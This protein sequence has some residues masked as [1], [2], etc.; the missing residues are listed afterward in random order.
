MDQI[1]VLDMLFCPAFSVKNGLIDDVNQDAKNMCITAGEPVE[2]MLLSGKTEYQ[3][4]PVGGCLSVLVDTETSEVRAFVC[5]QEDRDLFLLDQDYEDP[6]L[7]ALNVASNDLRLPLSLV[8]Q[9]VYNARMY[10]QPMDAKVEK[11]LNLIYKGAFQLL[12]QIVNMSD[13]YNYRQ[14]PQNLQMVNLEAL[15]R[16]TTQKAATLLEKNHIC[17]TFSSDVQEPD[18]MACAERLERALNNLILNAASSPSQTEEPKIHVELK[19]VEN[20]YYL[21][22]TDNGQGIEDDI[23]ATLFARF[24]RNPSWEGRRKG[25]GL[26]LT[27]VR[28][29]AIS[30]GG[31]LLVERLSPNGVR[32]TMTI[33]QKPY[34]RSVVSSG[35]FTWDYAS[36]FDHALMEF[37][38]LLPDEVFSKE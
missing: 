20:R 19:Q 4:L 30:H 32:A 24:R 26:G 15:F 16:E 6:T 37:S 11:S 35:R 33:K 23:F 36:E 8:M 14:M 12:R 10:G 13:G 34:D 2:N 17:I 31:A 1:R 25:I 29:A 38:K 22:V 3:D 5:R 9:G 18:T 7:M 27:L 21:S 28:S